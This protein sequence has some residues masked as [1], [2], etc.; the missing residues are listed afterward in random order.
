MYGLKLPV[1]HHEAQCL[2]EAID[3]ALH[4]PNE[5]QTPEMV[6]IH[7]TLKPTSQR[8]STMLCTTWRKK[9]FF[10]LK[11]SEA[12]ALLIFYQEKKVEAPPMTLLFL[13]NLLSII[14]QSYDQ[15]HLQ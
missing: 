9:K 15:N 8:I 11:A 10:S 14:A 12:A 3:T 2:Q 5:Q 13:Q 4:R 6:L 1:T 7:A